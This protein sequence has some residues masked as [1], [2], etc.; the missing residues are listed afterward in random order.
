MMQHVTRLIR[1]RGLLW[2]LALSELKAKHRQTALGMMWALLQPVSLMVVYAIVFSVFVSVPVKD[3]PYALFAYVGLVTWLFFATSLSTGTVSVVAQM[4]LITKANFPREVIPLAKLLAAGFDFAIG[5]GCFIILLVL[6]G[7]PVKPSWF[8]FPWVLLVHVFFTAGMVLWGS[9]LYVLKRDVG[10]L[11]PLILQVWMFL[12]PVIYPSDLIPDAYKA[13]YLLNPMAAIIE[14]YRGVTL[15]G[16]FP[17]F[18]IMAPAT[19]IALTVFIS[20]YAYFKFTEVRFAD[21]M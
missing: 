17:P 5:W 21:I 6:Y 20:G 18:A 3:V 9:A 7:T 19:V 11:L 1:Y 14:A 10:S 16:T 13:L 12:S 15:G 8:I 2:N 4:N